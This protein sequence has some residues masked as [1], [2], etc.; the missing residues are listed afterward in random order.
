MFADISRF[1]RDPNEREH[2]LVNFIFALLMCNVFI[3]GLYL[4]GIAP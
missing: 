1:I 2:Q 4:M 3:G